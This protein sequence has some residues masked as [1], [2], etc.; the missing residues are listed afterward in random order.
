MR[1]AF[2]LLGVMT[3]IV[4]IGGFFALSK[5]AEAPVGNTSVNPTTPMAFTLTSPAFTEGGLIPSKYTCDG[6]NLSPELHIGNVPPGTEALVLVMDDP[7]IP[8]LVKQSRGIE[9][10]DHW[11]VYNIPKDTVVIP[12]GAKSF[13]TSGINSAGSHGYRGPCPP[14]RQHRYFFRLYA[15]SGT[16]NF[17]K[18]PTLREVEEASRGMVLGE[19]TLMGKYE[20]EK[21]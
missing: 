14:D 2:T 13:G 9:T 20:R 21:N 4:F 15:V 7:D 17:L 11:V 19:A 3:L 8:D 12:E 6:E 5:K 10:F 1:H 18:A 16:L